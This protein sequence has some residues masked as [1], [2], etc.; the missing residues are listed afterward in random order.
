VTPLIRAASLDDVPALARI[1]ESCFDE[2]WDEDSFR[3]LLERPGAFA[4]V[5]KNAAATDLQS[6]V[7]IQAAADESEIL[8]LGTAPQ[9]RRAGFARA[10]VIEAAAEAGKR[11]ATAMFLEV[12]EDNAAALTLYR[13]LG[14]AANGRRRA[15]YQRVG[16]RHADALML[17]SALPLQ[18]HGND[19]PS[20]LD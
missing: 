6:F 7:L 9:M 11:A 3:R 8:S 4:L 10:L 12:A 13:G 20:R 17:R 5:A 16:G 15:Y 19:A 1:H 14:F 18:S 2:P